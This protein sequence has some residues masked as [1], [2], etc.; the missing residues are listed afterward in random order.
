MIERC[1][2]MPPGRAEPLDWA[3]PGLLVVPGYLDATRCDAWRAY[4]SRQ[5]ARHSMIKDIDPETGN[6]VQRLDPQRVTQVVTPGDL[7]SDIEKALITAYRETITPHYGQQLDWME[8][9][10]VLKYVPG[11]KYD[12]HADSEYWDTERRCWTRSIDR[13]FSL[14][15]YLN[16]DFEG[17]GLWFPNFDVRVRPSKGMLIAFPSDHRYLHAAEPVNAGERFVLVGWATVKGSPRVTSTPM[18]VFWA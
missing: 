14:L 16:D 7:K 9:P 13:D 15:L 17:G 3:P 4:L 6:A 10:G 2:D 12:G 5:P 8:P 18:G 1:G 11:G